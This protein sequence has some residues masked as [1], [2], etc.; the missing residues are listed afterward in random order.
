MR[1]GRPLAAVTFLVA[2]TLAG[3]ARAPAQGRFPPD[4]LHNLKY[5]PKTIAVRDLIDSMRTFTFALGVRCQFCHVGREGMPLDS[6][7]FRSDSLRTKRAARVMLDMV[8]HINDEHLGMVPD[9]PV[10]HVVVTCFTCHHGVNRPFDLATILLGAARAPGAGV[11]SVLKA[12]RA[13][14]AQYL[15]RGAYDFGEPTLNTVADGLGGERRWDD[16]LAVLKLNAEFYPAS[17]QIPTRM[18]EVY[19]AKGDTANAIA[20]Y[21]QALQA[22]AQNPMARRRLQQLGVPAAP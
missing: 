15:V 10:P 21:R 4:S 7:D 1:H 20:S 22:N 8:R 6:F 12:Y 3:T 17:T 18:G 5:F 19:L 2:L 9:R 13:L 14:R 11:D 16:A